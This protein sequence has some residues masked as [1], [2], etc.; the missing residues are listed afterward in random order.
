MEFVQ[1][2]QATAQVIATT[3]GKAW[4]AA[5]CCHR[6]L[7][8]QRLNQPGTSVWK[9]SHGGKRPF[10]LFGL[11][12]CCLDGDSNRLDGSGNLLSQGWNGLPV[13]HCQLAALMHLAHQGQQFTLGILLDC[14]HHQLW[15]MVSVEGSH[16]S[17]QCTKCV[18][19]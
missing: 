16:V 19:E 18:H 8:L 6:W 4:I 11:H 17:S 10:M 9:A 13:S 12:G 5:H 7:L 1:F 2:R 14:G 15:H 3:R